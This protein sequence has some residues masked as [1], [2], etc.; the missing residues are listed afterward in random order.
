[1]S[2]LL[3]ELIPIP[4]RVYRGDFVLRLAEGVADDQARRTLDEYVVTPQLA[5]AF[6]QALGLVRSAV[7]A[8]SSKAAYLHGSFGAGKS[9][10][11]AVLHMLLRHDPDARARPELGEVVA[12]HGGWLDGRR[13]LLPTYHLIGASSLEAAVLGGYV[14]HVRAVHP[15]APVPAVFATGAV[16]GT[17][18]VLRG[19]LGDEA[20]FAMLNR[21]AA[22]EDEGWGDLGGGWTAERYGAAAASDVTDAEHQRLVSDVVQVFMPTQPELTA[23]ARSYVPIDTGLAILSQHAAGLGYDGIVLFLDELILWLMSRLADQAFVSEEATKVAKLVEA[24]H[25][26]RPVPLVSFVA[27]QRDLRELVGQGIPG[28]E[29]LSLLDTL[30]W[31][32][33]RFATITLED[34][35]LPAIAERRLLRPKDEAAHGQIDDAFARVTAAMRDAL[36]IAL[37]HAA[38]PAAFRQTYPFTPAFIDALVAASSALQRERTALKVMADLLA[39]RRDELTID[40]LVPVGDLYDAIDASDEPFSAELGRLFAAA[41]D[42]YERK[43][44]PLLLIEHGVR[45]E[46]AA[47]NA[48]FGADDRLIKTLLL[49]ALVPD[50]PALRAL[51]ARRLVALNWGQVR[52]LFPGQ[53]ASTVV[54]KLRSW[55]AAVGELKL[56]E[57]AANPTAHLQLTGIDTDAIIERARANDTEGERRRLVRELLLGE[58]GIDP[59]SAL[60]RFEIV[61][62]FLWQGS[63]RAVEL[64]FDNVRDTER[65][66]DAA[67]RPSGDDPRLVVDLPF[68]DGV[69]GPRDDVARVQR[70]RQE[71]PA[72]ATVCWLPNFLGRDLQRDL[73]TL[74]I[75]ELLLTGERLQGYVEHL[76]PAERPVAR[77]LLD[78]Q[79]SALRARLRDA[80]A[81]AYA[82]TSVRGD[83]IDVLL[84]PA[85]QF[86]SLD[87]SF[88]PRP[89]VGPTLARALEGLCDQ[90]L[91]HRYP[92]HPAFELELRDPPL[93]VVLEET[94]RAV[95]AEADNH[96]IE[97]EQPRRRPLRAI[98]QPLKLGIQYETAFVLADH[99]RSHF[100]QRLAAS[101]GPFTVGALRQAIDVPQP[102]GLDRRL[103]DVL[104][105]VFAAQTRRSFWLHGAPFAGAAI[106][107]LDD[108]LELRD[109]RLPDEQTWREAVRRAATLFGLAASE[110][111]SAGEVSRLAGEV[112]ERG[113]ASQGPTAALLRAL[114]ARLGAL[115]IER[116]SCAR[117]EAAT[118]AMGLARDLANTD[119]DSS[120]DVLASAELGPGA[121]AVARTIATADSVAAALGSGWPAAVDQ[122]A[123]LAPTHAEA[124][125]LRR[126]VVDAVSR[127]ELSVPLVAELDRLERAAVALLGRLAAVSTPPPPPLAPGQ[128]P[129]R[130]FTR[131]DAGKSEQLAPEAADR[132]LD[133]LRALV[134]RDAAYRL[135][136]D[137]V[138][139]REERDG[140]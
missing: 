117:W 44:R 136:I 77:S 74:V 15:E 70:Y 80:L 55:A 58:F 86:Q 78:N 75:L 33:G 62:R 22:G 5:T 35:N 59:S 115:A 10:F 124:A 101:G 16:F 85:D 99:W 138:V 89:P 54:A 66:P 24:A 68:D 94:L 67:L 26:E 112:A 48:A 102:M 12:R 125:D 21:G 113:S 133:D 52:G 96:R 110:L 38:D 31:W 50:V 100:D 63:S 45:D 103:G 36:D 30:N 47:A 139:E 119:L 81:Q 76:A 104:I 53:E 134:H 128:P 29:Q 106:G 127:H 34:R 131:I 122:L 43:L 51:D 42:L 3:R 92:A 109:Q 60:D 73:G 27:R 72:C 49:A 4:E 7:E 107:R 1:M 83:A 130:G 9:H 41:R 121:E 87:P 69:Y 129:S 40:E 111:R 56:S 98:A 17:T 8:R 132:T 79:R 95:D 28:A 90:L 118:A 97:V 14:D 6:D 18:E 23:A 19:Q 46:E 11:M 88:E 64:A 61:H 93:R 120:V 114:E 65:L 123:A 135:T 13:F 140:A 84:D 105:L 71:Q 37:G 108:A 32:A 137:W 20:F 126:Q 116:G 2:T 39:T 25:A 57:D 82:A 91:R